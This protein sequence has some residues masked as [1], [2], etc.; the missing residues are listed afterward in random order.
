M[1]NANMKSLCFLCLPLCLLWFAPDSYGK[2]INYETARL[3]KRLRAVKITDKITIDGRL[4]EPVWTDAPRTTDRGAPNTGIALLISEFPAEL[5]KEYFGKLLGA[6]A[7]IEAVSVNGHEAYW[8]S[9]SAHQ[10]WRSRWY[11][12]WRPLLPR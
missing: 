12:T 4:D 2:D 3:E 1:L 5:G 9:G 7:S 10:F 6:G 8:L 11:L